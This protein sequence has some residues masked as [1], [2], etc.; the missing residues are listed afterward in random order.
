MNKELYD[1]KY[2]L[3]DNVYYFIKNKYNK[4]LTQNGNKDIKGFKRAKNIIDSNGKLTYQQLKRIKNYFDN[5]H[6][7]NK[8]EYELN[9]G[10]L[11]KNY[12]NHKLT[13]ER[14]KI[15]SSKKIKSDVGMENQFRKKHAKDGMSNSHKNTENLIESFLFEN[16]EYDDLVSLGYIFNKN[17]EI[18]LL[19]RHL[20][21]F[22]YPNHWGLVGGHINKK[23]SIIEGLLR[24][25]KEETGLNCNKVKFLFQER[26]N[27]KVMFMFI[28]VVDNNDVKLSNE[29]SD[30]GW[31]KLSKIKDL[32][33]KTPNL[34]Y[35]LLKMYNHT[36]K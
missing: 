21:D 19:K 27:T 11:M 6:Q 31:F 25:I 14:K 17:N 5:T 12:V 9:G 8:D 28:C 1:K 24:E 22:W 16:E 3:P 13:E 7:I 20:E 15:K 32:P 29:H 34:D 2:K 26:Y 30:Y 10:D 23:E 33:N 18:L 36:K 4:Y 35:L